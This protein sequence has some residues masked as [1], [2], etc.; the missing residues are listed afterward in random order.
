MISPHSPARPASRPPW[1]VLLLPGPGPADSLPPEEPAAP[2]VRTVAAPSRI[3]VIED[4]VDAADTLRDYLTLRGHEVR[5]A[6]SGPEGLAEAGRFLPELVLCDIGLPG[7][8]GWAVA[9]AL[10]AAPGTAGARL[11][12]VTGY[13]TEEDQRLSAE[14][15]FEAH[16]VKPLDLDVLEAL[17]GPRP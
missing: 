6:Y 10:R 16:L 11:V 17:L 9:R 5:V 3:L 2:S 8:D 4:N 13:G 14:A 15:G 7:M 1:P 12:A